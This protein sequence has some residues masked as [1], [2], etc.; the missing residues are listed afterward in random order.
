[1]SK[2]GYWPGDHPPKITAPAAIS[3]VD[4]LDRVKPYTPTEFGVFVTHP[5]RADKVRLVRTLVELNSAAMALYAHRSV[6]RES[7]IWSW[8]QQIIQGAA[9]ADAQQ[10]Q[11]AIDK[12]NL[13]GGTK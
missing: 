12:L 9:L 13:Q 7:V 6:T 5:D 3:Q 2:K 11:M 8:A 4:W 10:E 1:M